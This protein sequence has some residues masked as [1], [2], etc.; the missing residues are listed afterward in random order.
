M[1]HLVALT[2]CRSLTHNDIDNVI[3]V[4]VVVVIFVIFV[5]VVDIVVISYCRC[6]RLFNFLFN[7]KVASLLQ[8]RGKLNAMR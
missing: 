2:G 5:I 3:V 8:M 1:Q 4:V 7:N 6:Q